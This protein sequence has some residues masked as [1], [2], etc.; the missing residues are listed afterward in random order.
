MATSL[1]H[2]KD[3]LAVPIIGSTAS[4][5][6]APKVVASPATRIARNAA[7]RVIANNLVIGTC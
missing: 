6:P 7:K 4:S 1:F 3:Q 5:D 2:L